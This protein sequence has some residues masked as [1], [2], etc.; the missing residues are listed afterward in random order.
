MKTLDELKTEFKKWLKVSKPSAWVYD[1]HGVPSTYGVEQIDP[2]RIAGVQ[3]ETP[4]IYKDCR[5]GEVVYIFE[6]KSN[7]YVYDTDESRAIHPHMRYGVRGHYCDNG[8][9][10]PKVDI[11]FSEIF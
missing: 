10:I 9:F 1:S 3:F 2:V 8:K 7:D 5:R 11:N 6:H 4:V